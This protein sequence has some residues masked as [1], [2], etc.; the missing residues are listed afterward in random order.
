[1]KQKTILL[2]LLSF[3]A[4]IGVSTIIFL[5]MLVRHEFEMIMPKTAFEGDLFKY[6]TGESREEILQRLDEERQEFAKEKGYESREE[7]LQ[8]GDE[9]LRKIAQEKGYE[10]IEKWHESNQYEFE[11]SI[12]KTIWGEDLQGYLTG[13]SPE[14]TSKRIDEEKQKFAEKKGFENW[15]KMLDAEMD[16]IENTE[17][18][19][20]TDNRKDEDGFEQKD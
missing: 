17:E 19:E 9:A 11:I 18:Q 20:N 5:T 6:L 4:G 1:M 10:S 14:E 13:E 12:P 7:L 16:N 2:I 8:R 15:E 3:F